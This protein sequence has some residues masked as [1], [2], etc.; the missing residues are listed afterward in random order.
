MYTVYKV[1]AGVECIQCIHYVQVYMSV[2]AVA[3]VWAQRMHC[4]VY[5][6]YTCIDCIQAYSLYTV[7]IPEYIWWVFDEYIKNVYLYKVYTL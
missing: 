7:G 3:T 5:T 4:A 1:Y 6:L 2:D